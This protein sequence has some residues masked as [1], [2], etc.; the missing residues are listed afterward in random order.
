MFK[1]RKCFHIFSEASL[2]AQMV[3]NLPVMQNT[4]VWSQGQEDP[5]EKG[6]ATHCSSHS[7]ECL[8]NPMDR[9][10]WLATVHRVAKSNWATNTLS[11]ILLLSSQNSTVKK[12]HPFSRWRNWYWE[13]MYTKLHNEQAPKQNPQ[14]RPSPSKSII[15]T[16]TPQSL[17]SDSSTPYIVNSDLTS[18]YQQ[19]IIKHL[20]IKFIYFF[21]QYG[22]KMT[23]YLSL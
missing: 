14:P 23:I 5:L 11:H 19:K 15:L 17:C 2:V 7:G 21:S 22:G 16:T 12:Y 10:A 3:K 9:G 1:F 4:Q 18:L 6:M 13:E 20:L 8:E